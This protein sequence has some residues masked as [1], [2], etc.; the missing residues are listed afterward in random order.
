[1]ITQNHLKDIKL[2]QYIINRIIYMQSYV[3]CVY[4]IP[5]RFDV[6]KP[7]HIFWK[8]MQNSYKGE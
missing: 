8:L 4:R 7:D 2:I 1:M 3:Y 6:K 5:V